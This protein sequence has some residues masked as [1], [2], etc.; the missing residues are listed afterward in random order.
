[1]IDGVPDQRVFEPLG[2]V[3]DVIDRLMHVR[4]HLHEV[5]IGERRIDHQ[6]GA[7]EDLR[8]G[9]KRGRAFPR[10]QD[11]VSR[12]NPNGNLAGGTLGKH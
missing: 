3:A 4:R 12:R 9:L 2:L 1:M 7:D 6:E 10:R 11:C 8:V 5:E